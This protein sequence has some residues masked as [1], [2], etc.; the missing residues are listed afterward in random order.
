MAEQFDP[1]RKWLGI[2]RDEQPPHHYR[3]LGIPLFEADPDVIENAS[4]RQMSYL[5]TFQQ[6]PHAAESQQLLTELAAAKLCLLCPDRKAAYD[7]SLHTR[8]ATT[9]PPRMSAPEPTA[10]LAEVPRGIRSTAP[11]IP[12]RP[13]LPPGP[14]DEVDSSSQLAPLPP[15]VEPTEFGAPVVPSAVAPV[16]RRRLSRHQQLLLPLLIGTLGVVAVVVIVGLL[17]VNFRPPAADAPER[18]W[19]LLG[20]SSPQPATDPG[21][22]DEQIGK[23]PTDSPPSTSSPSAPDAAL[24]AAHAAR[25]RQQLAAVR[26][27]LANRQAKEAG[28]VL[29]RVGTPARD[30]Q[31]RAEKERL[32]VLHRLHEDF[33]KAVR[34]GIDR[35]KG[36]LERKDDERGER[37]AGVEFLGQQ[38]EWRQV[39]PE[40]L[41]MQID[42]ST[43]RGTWR[44]LPPKV[45]VTF[46]LL[47]LEDEDGFGRNC[48]AAFLLFDSQ[49][50]RDENRRIG[51]AFY[52]LATRMVGQPNHFLAEEF[53]LP[54]TASDPP[55][56]PDT[57]L[58]VRPR[59]RRSSS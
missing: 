45:A 26:T 16:A 10:A 2:P 38:L 13:S 25:V 42:G 54:T 7:E 59:L 23:S 20:R 29:R 37:V 28:D 56:Y 57:D 8:L 1:Y 47:G 43:W 51:A 9:A 14:V 46:A 41:E 58:Q 40:A 48:L 31:L 24:V 12:R 18:W 17:A 5:R 15:P 32:E 3:L 36:R 30:R 11:E 27:A 50:S 33:W 22:A 34:K 35:V 49:G 44:E 52:D 4:H 21:A 55:P 6:G 53:G 19:G 39:E